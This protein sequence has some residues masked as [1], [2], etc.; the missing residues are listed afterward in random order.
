MAAI[1]LAQLVLL[2]VA[3]VLVLAVLLRAALVASYRRGAQV[4]FRIGR[5]SGTG[6]VVGRSLWKVRVTC[7]STGKTREVPVS[8]LS[9]R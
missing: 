9:R 7:V 3:S 6:V 8:R 2:L 5:G 1:S 4:E